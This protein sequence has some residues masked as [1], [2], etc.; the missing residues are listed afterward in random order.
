MVGR[1]RI[2]EDVEQEIEGLARRGHTNAEILD[3]LARDERFADRLPKIGTVKKYAGPARRRS[4]EPWRL[5]ARVVEPAD[6]RRLLDIVSTV[7]AETDGRLTYITEA[8]AS[9]LATILRLADLGD[10]DAYVLAREAVAAGDEASEVVQMALLR[11]RA[12]AR[13]S[14]PHALAGYTGTGQRYE[15]VDDLL[16][17]DHDHE[18]GPDGPAEGEQR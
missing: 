9:W 7:I 5:H 11:K 3:A 4:G 12:E 1:P 16:A 2:D 10:W 14:V 8:E 6:E 13:G 18:D 17:R 15:T